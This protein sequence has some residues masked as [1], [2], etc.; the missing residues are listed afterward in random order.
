MDFIQLLEGI[1]GIKAKIIF[2]PM[3]QGDVYATYA[4][5]DDL[6]EITGFS[7]VTSIETGLRFFV[8]WYRDYYKLVNEIIN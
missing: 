3:Q 6:T 7:P 4:D 1:I 5:I 8:E 2:K